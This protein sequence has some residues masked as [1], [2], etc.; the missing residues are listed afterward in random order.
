[1]LELVS[2]KNAM[3]EDR[4]SRSRSVHIVPDYVDLPFFPLSFYKLALPMPTQSA[5]GIWNDL[6]VR[7]VAIV[8]IYDKLPGI[9]LLG[10][11][12]VHVS[13]LTSEI[14]CP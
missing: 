5:L 10:L 2:Q 11:S 4:I 9:P 13:S 7:W 1:M 6:I 14:P 8:T 12:H 3:N